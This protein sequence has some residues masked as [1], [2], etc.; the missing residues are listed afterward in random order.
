MNALTPVW[1]D[2]PRAAH[3]TLTG[4][5]TYDDVVVG[6]GL[7]GLLTG[8]FLARAGRKVAVLE[9]RRVADGTTGRTTAKVSLL[10]G[11]RLSRVVRTNPP[12][13]ARD[14]V[15][16][17]R[18]GQ[19]WLERFCRD[20]DVPLQ[21]RP[22]YTYATTRVGEVKAQAELAA[23]RLAGLDVTWETETELPYPVRG[24][25]R[26]ADQLQLHP[27]DLV[28]ALVAELLAEG[29]DLFE[30]TRVRDLRRTG[31]GVRVLA[32]SATATARTVVLA[33]NQPILLRHGFFARLKAER[34][35]CAALGTARSSS[36]SAATAT[37]PG[38]GP[39]PATSS[40]TWSRGRGR[41]S[42]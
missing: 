15:E 28:D 6:A 17:N 8:L 20:H 7:T 36:W 38:A 16:A 21:V 9:A 24:T 13:V 30:Q 22:A 4:D 14:Y 34:S 5:T 40:T 32:G 10:Q 19:A 31:D 3:P 29:G 42:R 1:L 35:Y 27:M 2:R 39:R 41:R 11:T 12:S 23:A 26:L 25:V 33:T 18:E 37:A